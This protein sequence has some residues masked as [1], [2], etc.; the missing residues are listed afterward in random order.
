M[1][2]VTSIDNA[3]AGEQ[4][5]ND[6]VMTV[7]AMPDVGSRTDSEL[8]ALFGD[9][10]SDHLRSSQ[11]A[12]I[13]VSRSCGCPLENVYNVQLCSVSACNDGAAPARYLDLAMLVKPTE[14]SNNDDVVDTFNYNASVRY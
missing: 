5:L 6:I 3:H 9:I 7:R 4:A 10:A 14:L 2:T 12:L 13:N 8:T 11:F 1:S